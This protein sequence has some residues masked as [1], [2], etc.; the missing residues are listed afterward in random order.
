MGI[1]ALAKKG[2]AGGR[3]VLRDSIAARSLAMDGFSATHSTCLGAMSECMHGLMR[4]AVNT[5]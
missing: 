4:C 5:F 2:A 3:T 1:V